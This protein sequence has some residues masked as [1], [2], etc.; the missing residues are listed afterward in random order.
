[1]HHLQQFYTIG[2]LIVSNIFMTFAW[3]GHLKLQQIK[4]FTDNTPLYVIIL[5]SWLLALPEYSCQVPANRIGFDGNGGPFNIMQLKVIQE[6]I[7]LTVFTIIILFVFKGQA[8]QW[9]HIAAFVCLILAVFFVF[10]K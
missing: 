7:S 1:M 4:I 3:Y 5:L 8:L 10:L 6:V 9:N 2:L